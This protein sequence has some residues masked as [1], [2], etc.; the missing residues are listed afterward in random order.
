M[1]QRFTYEN[2]LATVNNKWPA[3]SLTDTAFV[4]SSYAYYPQ[5]DQL[6]NNAN[7]NSGYRV[8]TKS[9]QLSTRH[10]IMTDLI[11]EWTDIPHRAGKNPTAINIVWGDGHASV[12]TS[13]TTF[14]PSA[15]YW[16]VAAGIGNGPGE[17]GFNQ[18]FL[19]I[20]ATIQD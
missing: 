7:S 17:P 18:N 20:M 9:T 14:N 10:S 2:Y 11:Y 13:N 4:R 3:Y 8:A 19:N 12:F 16:N 1:D 15:Q 6:V 5:T